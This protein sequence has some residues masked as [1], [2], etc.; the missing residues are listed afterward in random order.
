MKLL[1]AFQ[2]INENRAE[3]RTH[4]RRPLR[5]ALN[6]GFVPLHF[7]T[8]LTAHVAALQPQL[9]PHVAEGLYGDLAG[10]L[11]RLDPDAVDAVVAM[12]E[13]ADLDPRLGARST[14]GWLMESLPDIIRTVGLQLDGSIARWNVFVQSAW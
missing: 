2:I 4:S 1:Q 11:E 12:I 9:V 8:F 5:L 7:K 13:W 10:N 3:G 14:G 6:C